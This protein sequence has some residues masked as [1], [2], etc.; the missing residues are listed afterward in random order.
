MRFATETFTAFIYLYIG[1]CF[2]LVGL[3]GGLFFFLI[4]IQQ[5][6]QL[7]LTR[8]MQGRYSARASEDLR[9]SSAQ[10]RQI[11]ITFCATSQPEGHERADYAEHLHGKQRVNFASV[12]I[13]PQQLQNFSSRND[14]LLLLCTLSQKIRHSTKCALN[15]W[16][17]VIDEKKNIWKHNS[18]VK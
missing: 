9:I 3:C 13:G 7:T 12:C 15:I 8:N 17:K 4:Y 1:Y 18:S 16:I 2:I 10:I 14:N 5:I 11:K 6:S